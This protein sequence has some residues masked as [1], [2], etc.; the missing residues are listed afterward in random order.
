MVKMRTELHVHTRY[1]HDSILFL[2]LLAL[3]CH[4]K[5]IKCVA[6][7][8]HNTITGAQ[9]AQNLFSKYGI[10]VIVGEEIFSA[11][12]EIIGLYL[13]N[14]IPSGLCAEETVRMIKE[15]NGLVMIPHPY[16]EKRYKTVLKTK[17][18]YEIS[19]N[20]DLI[21]IY[22]GRNV[23]E[24]YSV[25]QAEIAD[26]VVTDKKVAMIAGSDAH[27][28][29]ELGRNYMITEIYNADDPFSFKKAMIAADRITAKCHPLAHLSTKFA[30]AVKLIVRG[31]SHELFRAIYRRR[32]K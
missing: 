23:S 17:K 15:Q 25:K 21:E 20:I 5:K 7:C 24:K 9:K 3:K 8:D 1:S 4:W 14:P 32:K 13:K 29:L 10:N 27:T 16:D 12:G 19:D 31:E 26:S 22:N 28:F 30:R 11:D 6:I 2:N 18:L